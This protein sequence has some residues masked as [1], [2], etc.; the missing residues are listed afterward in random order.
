MTVASSADGRNNLDLAPQKYLSIKGNFQP[1]VPC[2]NIHHEFQKRLST[3]R[4]ETEPPGECDGELFTERGERCCGLPGRLVHKS[5]NKTSLQTTFITDNHSVRKT[6]KWFEF[7]V[8]LSHPLLFFSQ[9]GRQLC[10]CVNS[11]AVVCQRSLCK[12]YIS[13]S[14]SALCR[15]IIAIVNVAVVGQQ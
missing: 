15:Y 9:A 4:R 11:E 13:K 5:Q 2:A 12:P 1:A 3:S 8:D 7:N 6:L 10:D 14:Y